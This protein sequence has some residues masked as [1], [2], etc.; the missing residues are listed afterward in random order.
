MTSENKTSIR[1][2]SILG[3]KFINSF[4]DSIYEIIKD[5][6]IKVSDQIIFDN[7][8]YIEFIDNMGYSYAFKGMTTNEIG[9]VLYGYRIQNNMV[10]NNLKKIRSLSYNKAQL[11]PI[12][13]YI[14]RIYNSEDEE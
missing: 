2:L 10:S 11:I 12:I 14:N 7:E 5:K 13:N 9:I 1:A 4:A 8:E 6:E 3:D